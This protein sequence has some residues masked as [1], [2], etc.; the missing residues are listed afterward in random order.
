MHALMKR[1]LAGSFLFSA[2]LAPFAV[3]QPTSIA[4]TDELRHTFSS[5]YSYSSR[6]TLDRGGPAG[7]VGVNR[8][9][10]AF[11]QRP[12]LAP[13]AA[14]FSYGLAADLH[15]LDT[16]R[17]TPLPAQLNEVAFNLGYTRPLDS[18]WTATVTLRPGLYGDFEDI[19]DRTFNA[20]LLLG[21]AYARSRELIWLF[22]LR[23][24]LRSDDPVLPFVGVR[25]RF[26]D[27]WSLNLAFP[28]SGVVWQLSPDL[29]LDAGVSLQGGT[30]HISKS[31]GSPAGATGPLRD[32]FV[33]YRE[34]RVG[35]G[36]EFTLTRRATLRLD[37]GAFTD[38]KFEYFKRNYTLNGDGRFYAS[39]A[40]RSAF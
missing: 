1:L 30:Y 35:L 34:I 32:T 8:V 2:T 39:V 17:G 22:G 12:A 36:A 10:F 33:D 29:A 40:L 25:W 37:A 23:A 27:D 4:R 13:A 18:R 16:T 19:S 24:D 3:A 20:P 7:E 28:R 38:R 6:E 26:A 11:T 21:A 9:S 14:G 5:E 15:F 31:L